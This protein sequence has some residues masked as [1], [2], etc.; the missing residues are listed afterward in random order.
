[1]LTLNSFIWQELQINV[2]QID[3]NTESQTELVSTNKKDAE[4][5]RKHSVNPVLL[6]LY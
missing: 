2:E 5:I 1:M 3:A 4:F 6:D